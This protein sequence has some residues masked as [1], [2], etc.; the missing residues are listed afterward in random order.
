MAWNP[1]LHPRDRYGRFTR[2]YARKLSA[3]DITA[4]RGAMS[5]F[6]PT[7]FADNA[8]AVRFLGDRRPNLSPEV[9]GAVDRYTGDTFMEI[10]KALRGGDDSHP[11]VAR[12]DQAAV[13]T[14]TDLIVTRTVGMDAFGDVN[15]EDLAGMKVTDAAYASTS[16][17]A[18][19]SSLAGV[20]MH[21][22]VPKG[23]PAIYASAIS[24]NVNEAEMILPRGTSMAVTKVVPRTV[25][26]QVLKGLYDMYLVVL[27]KKESLP[28]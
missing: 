21:I 12:L 4:A 2:S 10:N 15:P 8:A 26:G 13:P 3:A 23:T 11:D 19:H 25:N 16:L 7:R 17:G 1:A 14:D 27:P 5:G 24:R 18:Q 9:E 20:T 28:S 22:A 6:R